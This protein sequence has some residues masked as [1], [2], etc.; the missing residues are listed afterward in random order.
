[1]GT[2]S[3][4]I[5]VA[6][7]LVYWMRVEEIMFFDEYWSDARFARKKPNMR[8]SMMH[9]YGDNIYWTGPDG[10]FQQLNSFHSEDDGSLSVPNRK[11]DTGTTQ[12]VLIGCVF[13]YFGKSA[14]LI[15][16]ELGFAVKKGPGH[17]CQFVNEE[18]IAVEDWLVTL[19]D[20]GY[21]NEPRRW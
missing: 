20:R 11:R 16:H 5:G 15:P 9:R 1:M 8:G 12:K 3:A 13:A 18:R 21:V 17:K 10:T 14:P 6:N 19:P 2:G 4:D 7:H